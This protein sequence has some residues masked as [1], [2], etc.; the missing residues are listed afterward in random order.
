M[1]N[2]AAFQEAGK[3]L[4]GGYSIPIALF[5]IAAIIFIVFGILLWRQKR[6]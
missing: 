2:Y 6:P 1:T 3:L 4:P 5:I